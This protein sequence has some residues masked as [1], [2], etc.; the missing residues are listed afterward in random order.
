M[1]IMYIDKICKI[2]APSSSKQA[3]K[4]VE[5]SLKKGIIA[6]K[7][8]IRSSRG[9]NRRMRPINPGQ[10]EKAV[11]VKKI[12]TTLLVKKPSIML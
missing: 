8:V 5:C 9:K 12:A 1:Q 7:A 3:W 6:N 2:S 10:M 11:T 4:P